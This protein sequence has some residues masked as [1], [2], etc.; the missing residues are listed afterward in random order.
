MSL[1]QG[2]GQSYPPNGCKTHSSGGSRTF[3][4]KTV[5]V[6]AAAH[7]AKP[8]CIAIDWESVG[9]SEVDAAGVDQPNALESING[10]SRRRAVSF[11]KEPIFSGPHDR[12]PS[13]LG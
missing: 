4:V 3:S 11:A 9:T 1:Q 12:R 2:I 6:S 8:I 13:V 7:K 10:I 5:V